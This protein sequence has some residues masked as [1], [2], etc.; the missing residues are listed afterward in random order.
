M[1][2]DLLLNVN[3]CLAR[4]EI[5]LSCNL[6]FHKGDPGTVIMSIQRRQDAKFHHLCILPITQT[7]PV[8][9]TL[10]GFNKKKVIEK[11]KC[12]SPK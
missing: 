7:E 2:Y 5:P 11:V 12:A 8:S 10:C 9:K 3:I 6:K 4:L 1:V